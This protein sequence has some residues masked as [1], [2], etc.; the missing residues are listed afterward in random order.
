M[1]K[2]I[3]YEFSIVYKAGKNNGAVD[4]L[5]QRPQEVLELGHYWAQMTV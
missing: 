2:L 1:M 3:G 5:S 4:A